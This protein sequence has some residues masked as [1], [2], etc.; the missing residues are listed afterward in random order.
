MMNNFDRNEPV[1]MDSTAVMT[2]KECPRKYFYRMVLGFVPPVKLPYFAYG[3]AYHKF[4]EILEIEFKRGTEINKCILIG[5]DA[6]RDYCKQH[7]VTPSDGKWSW[8]TTDALIGACMVAAKYWVEEKQSGHIE[9][10]ATEQPFRIIV[11]SKV[12]ENGEIIIAGRADQIIKV[13]N[14]I[15]GRDFKTTSQAG[16]K[17][18]GLSPFYVNSIDPNDQFTRYTYAESILQFGELKDLPRERVNGQYIEVIVNSAKSAPKI[19]NLIV[20]KTK[21]Q[22]EKWLE[23]HDIWMEIMQVCRSKDEWPMNEKSCRFCE[24]RKVCTLSS[25]SM[26]MSELKRSYEVNHW[27][28]ENITEIGDT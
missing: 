13:S 24:Y 21:T 3:S 27:D 6:A 11:P 12:A 2:F 4:R 23:E 17:D 5:L 9:V 1:I 19:E 8:M 14:R 10:L 16:G 28:C 7:L 22:L 25:E 26:Q 15:W 18:G 20:N